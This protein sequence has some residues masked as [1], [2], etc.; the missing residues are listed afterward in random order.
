MA[1]WEDHLLPLLTCED[2]A[3]LACTCKALRVVV[4]EHFVGDLRFILVE[5]L[6]AALTTFPRARSLALT[7][8]MGSWGDAE[9][10]ALMEWLREGGR[11]ASITTLTTG[12]CDHVVP[13]VIHAALRGGALP[14]LQA[15]KVNLR[16][17]SHRALLT[18]GT[19]EA[20]ASCF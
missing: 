20:C 18:E 15:V 8:G 13:G 19:S 9:R 11:G 10:E 5:Q 16:I 6:Q 7:H 2:A 4:R 3:R 1:V 14:S 12:S 17:D